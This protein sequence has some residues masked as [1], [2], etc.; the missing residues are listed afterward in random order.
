MKLISYKPISCALINCSL[1]NLFQ[2]INPVLKS[3][4]GES[5]FNANFNIHLSLNGF[6][7]LRAISTKYY[8][9]QHLIGRGKERQFYLIF[10]KFVDKNMRKEENHLHKSGSN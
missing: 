4:T 6:L 5:I 2:I 1:R 10:N 8:V 9:Y 3:H 7:F